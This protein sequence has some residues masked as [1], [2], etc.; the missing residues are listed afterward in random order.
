MLALRNRILSSHAHQVSAHL[1][2]LYHFLKGIGRISASGR[3]WFQTDGATSLPNMRDCLFAVG[4]IYLVFTAS[5]SLP[6][7]HQKTLSSVTAHLA[8][9]SCALDPRLGPIFIRGKS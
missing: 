7:A 4:Y 2:L 8:A 3:L 1:L 6:P 9:P 5:M